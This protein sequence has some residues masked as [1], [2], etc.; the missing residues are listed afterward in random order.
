MTG[1]DYIIGGMLLVCV[2]FWVC[3]ILMCMEPPEG[4]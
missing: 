1:V 2:F 3:F 4:P